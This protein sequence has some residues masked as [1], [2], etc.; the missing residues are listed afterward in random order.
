MRP[1]QR[2]LILSVAALVA[3]ACAPGAG[4]APAAP[5]ASKPAAAGKPAGASQPAAAPDFSGRTIRLIVGLGAGGGY[6]TYYR[7]IA[8]HITRYLPGHPTIIVEN[9]TGGGSLVAANYLAKRAKPDGLTVGDFNANMILQAALGSKATQFTGKDFRWIGAPST[10]KPACVF[11]AAS[12]VR[13]WQDVVSSG[14][15][16]KIG[17]TRV[18]STTGDLPRILDRATPANFKMVEGYDGTAE[19]RRALQAREVD[20]ACWGWESITVTAKAM[21]DAEGDDKLIPMVIQGKSDD[22]WSKDVPPVSAVIADPDDLSAFLAWMGPYEFERPLALPPGTPDP[23]V[24]VWRD[25]YQK[26]LQDPEFLADAGR[27]KLLIEPVSGEEV[28][29]AV[30]RIWS[31]SPKAK[32]SLQFLLVGN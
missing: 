13:S 22:P 15:E 9:M 20:G 3:V 2:L 17:A 23:I 14:K 18:G 19:I 10:G 25:A 5:A 27:A 12:G 6:D 26:T 31:I 24:A 30:D 7:V 28:D 21:L 16:F 11:M 4:P 32:E 1:G 29:Q 8:Q